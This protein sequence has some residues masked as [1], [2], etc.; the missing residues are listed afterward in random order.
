MESSSKIAHN[1]WMVINGF[2]GE[3]D[4]EKGFELYCQYQFLKFLLFRS[5]SQ[6]NYGILSVTFNK[7]GTVLVLLVVLLAQAIL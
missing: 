7:A 2:M 6:K 3:L 4:V 5:V 1:F